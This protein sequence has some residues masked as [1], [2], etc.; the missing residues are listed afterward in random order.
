LKRHLIGPGSLAASL[1]AHCALVGAGALLIA[2]WPESSD[3]PERVL[4]VSLAEDS[5]ELPLTGLTA[6]VA[7]A[8]DRAIEPPALGAAQVARPD[9]RRRGRGGAH[10]DAQALNLSS[11]S[12]GIT[13][14]RAPLNHL[15]RSQA[16]HEHTAPRRASTDA[17]SALTLPGELTLL[18]DGEP[19]GR[20]KI[21]GGAPGR[22]AIAESPLVAPRAGA[23]LDAN[24]TD[25][26]LPVAR[27]AGSVEQRTGAAAE[28]SRLPA[29]GGRLLS[30]RPWVTRARPSSAARPRGPNADDVDSDQEVAA[31]VTSLIQAS[32]AGGSPGPG[33]GGTPAPGV[34]GSD[35]ASGAGSTS[36]A[37]GSG[38][39][40]GS[41][42]SLDPG[43]Q[44][45]YR[46]LV[47]RLSYALRDS[48]PDWA[49]REGRSGLVVF[50]M[51][52]LESGRIAAVRVVR[53]SGIA[54]YDRNVIS[55]VWRVGT[56]DPLPDTLGREAVVKMSWDSLNPVV[57]REGRG[58]G[59]RGEST[60]P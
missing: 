55:R 28:R 31:R 12:D 52:L 53:P 32:T 23:E 3:Q 45:Y 34:P 36:S 33:P 49:I 24:A 29:S 37:Q 14:D 60:H 56:F 26:G 41:D 7:L 10:A 27:L 54:E 30:A 22:F 19:A 40:P 15:T 47:A 5:V 48:F 57:G 43:L 59:G 46:A 13:L 16:L 6:G 9:L 50:E 38:A 2:A 18:V 1:V 51:R 17:R 11:S 44:G 21:P 58:P 25:V 39:G 4:E 42:R 20:F 8:A 35:G